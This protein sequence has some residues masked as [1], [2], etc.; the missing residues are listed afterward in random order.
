MDKQKVLETSS[1]GY[2]FS[3]MFKTLKRLRC[4]RVTFYNLLTGWRDAFKFGP[5][6]QNDKINKAAHRSKLL[7]ELEVDLS[8]SFKN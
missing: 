5:F 1:A 4:I 6:K 8:V 3:H 2:I 7:K